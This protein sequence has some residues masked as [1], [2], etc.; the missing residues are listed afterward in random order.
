MLD[1]TVCGLGDPV[2]LSDHLGWNLYAKSPS[3]RKVDYEVV[4]QRCLRQM[5]PPP[6]PRRLTP[7][8]RLRRRLSVG[9]PYRD[10]LGQ[11]DTQIAKEH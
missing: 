2:R 10:P 5:V 3:G 8:L 6:G 7:T 1:G 9:R 4:R 11:R